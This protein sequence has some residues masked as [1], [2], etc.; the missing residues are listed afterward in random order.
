MTND[1]G[2]ELIYC[3]ICEEYTKY[4]HWATF[5]RNHLQKFHSDIT[6][7]E[8]HD[9]YL[10]TKDNICKVCGKETD[11]ISIGEGYKLHCSKVCANMAT[12]SL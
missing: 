6:S 10:K 1:K 5:V 4:R 8:Y 7:K 12:L 9:M 3:H 2:R 11:F